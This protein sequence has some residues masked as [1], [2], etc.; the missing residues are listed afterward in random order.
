MLDKIDYKIRSLGPYTSH[1]RPY[2]TNLN[3]RLHGH[4]FHLA[5]NEKNFR[6]S[7]SRLTEFQTFHSRSAY[8]T[9][10][11]TPSIFCDGTVDRY[12]DWA[13]TPLLEQLPELAPPLVPKPK[14]TLQDY[15]SRSD[16]RCVIGAVDDEL[17]VKS[18]EATDDCEQDMRSPK[19]RYNLADSIIRSVSA[20]DVEIIGSASNLLDH[21]PTKVSINGQELY[22]DTC[23][24]GTS[25]RVLMHIPAYERVALANLPPTARVR[26]LEGVVVRDGDKVPLGLLFAPFPHLLSYTGYGTKKVSMVTKGKWIKQLRE[27]VAILHAA[28]V[29]WGSVVASNVYVDDDE[30]LWVGGFGT[31]FND[32]W[33]SYKKCNTVEGDLQA[34]EHLVN[35]IDEMDDSGVPSKL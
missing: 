25:T 11:S 30:N 6:N 28:G 18:L 15:Y 20:A 3:L 16:Y 7:P 31:C 14:Y 21:T 26:S 12:F 13:L 35:W 1:E 5:I 27:A 32:K 8:R 2:W 23:D 19:D 10:P 24:C 34:L 4:T 22:F 29:V 9:D 33:V 17:I